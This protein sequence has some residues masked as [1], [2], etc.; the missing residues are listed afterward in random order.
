MN[1]DSRDYTL[2]LSGV[3]NS[4]REI[5]SRAVVFKDKGM[6]ARH[7]LVDDT[8]KIRVKVNLPGYEF[9]VTIVVDAPSASCT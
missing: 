6:K 8:W 1:I 7:R 9:P 5:G 3:A 4:I 2:K